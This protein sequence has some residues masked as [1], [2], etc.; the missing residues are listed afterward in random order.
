MHTIARSALEVDALE[1][2]ETNPRLV[3]VL[4][5]STTG[6]AIPCRLMQSCVPYFAVLPERLS[7]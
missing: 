2:F 7:R 4:A 6:A 3:L 1:A 5:L